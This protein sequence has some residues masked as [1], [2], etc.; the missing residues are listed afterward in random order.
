MLV[1]VKASEKAALN[2]HKKLSVQAAPVRQ[3]LVRF[4]SSWAVSN[5]MHTSS[6][7]N[8]YKP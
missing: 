3:Y 5:R 4:V 7:T 1:Q 8:V 6:S 2:V